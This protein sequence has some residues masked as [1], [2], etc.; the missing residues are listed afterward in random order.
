MW[1]NTE[2]E[3]MRADKFTKM[4]LIEGL[5]EKL[6]TATEKINDELVERMTEFLP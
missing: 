6:A 4:E 2:T 1:F 3:L 5:H